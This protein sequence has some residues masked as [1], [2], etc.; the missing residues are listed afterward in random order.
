MKRKQLSM[1]ETDIKLLKIMHLVFIT[2]EGRRQASFCSCV[3]GQDSSGLN[4]SGHQEIGEG[5]QKAGGVELEVQN[6]CQ[7]RKS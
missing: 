1:K 6:V 7:K 5:R 4:D 3:I 2:Y